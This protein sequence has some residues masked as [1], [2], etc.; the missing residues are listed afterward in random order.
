MSR[1]VPSESSAFT[2][3]NPDSPSRRVQAQA[4]ASDVAATA[5]I[6]GTSSLHASTKSSTS[7]TS[8]S[9]AAATGSSSLHTS[10]LTPK[11]AKAVRLYSNTFDTE[12]TPDTLAAMLADMAELRGR[13]AM[14]IAT[15][16]ANP[17]AT[18]VGTTTSTSTASGS[19]H[20]TATTAPTDAGELRP[21]KFLYKPSTGGPRKQRDLNVICRANYHDAIQLLHLIH[22]TYRGS[23]LAHMLRADFASEMSVGNSSVLTIGDQVAL[24]FTPQRTVAHAP[25]LF[26]ALPHAA[27]AATSSSAAALPLSPPIPRPPGGGIHATSASTLTMNTRGGMHLHARTAIS[28]PSSTSAGQ[29]GHIHSTVLPPTSSSPLPITPHKI[30]S[31]SSIATATPTPAFFLS[32]DPH[33]PPPPPPST[34]YPTPFDPAAPDTHPLPP[35]LQL[36]PL[37][38]LPIFHAYAFCRLY[39]FMFSIQYR[40]HTHK[41]THTYTS[42]RIAFQFITTRCISYPDLV[43]SLFR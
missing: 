15:L 34:P 41:H 36:P 18:A 13:F 4:L 35:G 6:A 14:S 22:Q 28:T 24:N 21:L 10:V 37:P 9:T 19:N 26:T 43:L 17:A 8:S 25:F 3:A 29:Q 33:R 42:Y 32:P 39:Q 7:N 31:S 30:S 38:P 23:R 2:T 16:L 1:L 27:S 40:Q 12:I 5:A 11:P 20:G